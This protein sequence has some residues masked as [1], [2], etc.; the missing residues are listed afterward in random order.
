ML[1]SNLLVEQASYIPATFVNRADKDIPL[2]MHKQQ[3]KLFVNLIYQLRG[4]YPIAKNA[5]SASVFF[6]EISKDLKTPLR[7]DNFNRSIFTLIERGLLT[8]EEIDGVWFIMLNSNAD[9]VVNTYLKN[10][11]TGEILAELEA[12]SNMERWGHYYERYDVGDY[13]NTGV[14]T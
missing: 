5:I 9:L 1:I 10:D 7:R 12:N 11:P 2:S 4:G 8:T 6:R 3:F 13:D 14:M